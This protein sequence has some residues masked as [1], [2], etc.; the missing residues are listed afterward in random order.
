MRAWA[1]SS[2]NRMNASIMAN[3]LDARASVADVDAMFSHPDIAGGKLSAEEE[4]QML[5]SM[6]Y[7]K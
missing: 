4:A 3:E 2:L 7:N 6:L 5:T 1:L